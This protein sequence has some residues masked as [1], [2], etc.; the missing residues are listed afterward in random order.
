MRC[1]TCHYSLQGLRGPEHVCPE[2]GTEFDPNDV[3]TPRSFWRTNLEHPS[4]LG[5]VVLLGAIFLVMF[6]I[7]WINHYPWDFVAGACVLII[8]ASPVVW[9][10]YHLVFAIARLV[11]QRR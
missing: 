1:K 4:Q 7:I 8:L 3:D 11:L 6:A 10:L 5:V 2:C 9:T